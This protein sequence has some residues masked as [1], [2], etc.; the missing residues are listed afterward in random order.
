MNTWGKFRTYGNVQNQTLSTL[1]WDGI[2]YMFWI[3][4]LT[5]VNMVVVL[6]APIAYN[7]SLDIVQLA[8]QSTFASR[9]F[10]NL[11]EC[12]ERLRDNQFGTDIALGPLQFSP[13]S[14]G[15][16]QSRAL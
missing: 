2:M 5:G 1:Y 12:D 11:R 7:P 3:I 15:T 9:I 13:H 10:F 4:L 16:S 8:L 14:V 6:L